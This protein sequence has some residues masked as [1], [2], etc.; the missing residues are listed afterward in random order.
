MSAVTRETVRTEAPLDASLDLLQERKARWAQLPV[1]DKIRYLEEVLD[2]AIKRAPDWVAAGAAMK[3]LNPGS[4]LIGSEEWLAGPY[5][6][7]AWLHD[8]IETL[9]DLRTGKDP[10][11]GVPTSRTVTGQVAARVLPG[12]WYD[13]LL[14]NG[15][16]LDVWMQPGVTQETLRGTIAT[17]YREEDPPGRVT[18]VLGAG[19]VSAIPI[20]DALY[21]LIADGD[22]VVLKLNP[23]NV[24]YGPV[25]E[26][27]LQPL[28]RD[29]YLQLVYGGA[30]T[31][32]YLTHHA[33]VEAIHITG[34]ER[35]YNQIVFG[36]PEGG[37]SPVLTKPVRAELGG[38]GPTIVLPGPWSRDEIAYQAENLATQK[39]HSS[40]HTCVA[41]QILVLPAEWQHH[42]ALLDELR[43]ALRDAPQRSNYYPGAADRLASFAAANPGAEVIEGTDQDRLLLAGVDPASD[44]PAFREELF[45]PVYVAT[46]L[47]GRDTAEYLRSAV[48]FA[49][50]ALHGNLGANII[51]H[52]STAKH[53]GSELDQAVADLR[54]GCIGINAWAGV[55]FL[56]SKGAWG[57]HPGNTPQDI[58]SGTG[59]VHNALLFDRAEKNVLTAP[60]R[61]FP[62]GVRHGDPTLAVKPPWFVTNKT[63][64]ATARQLTHFAADPKP[65]RL[66][67]LFA[68]ALRG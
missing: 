44:H 6:T 18:L 28:I 32:E 47:A 4:P 53:L 16:T 54:Y 21:A 49:N 35:T 38:V 24:C 56:A 19:N 33:S 31:G 46:S 29:G 50:T 66:V 7:V 57:A 67:G 17:F 11:A 55:V 30:E 27:I 9:E 59:A 2:L 8:V 1:I 12:S 68:S 14:F 10:L 65:Q 43:A 51:V 61:T 62:M 41:S 60:F 37:A 15:F 58:Q 48:R 3:G 20:L 26:A 23:V 5:P 36:S 45:G 64:E 39:L 25:F 52:P 22:V 63:A 42:D 34:S 40:G 13:H